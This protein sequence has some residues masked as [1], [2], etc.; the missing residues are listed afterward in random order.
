[1][2]KPDPYTD[3]LNSSVQKQ[4]QFDEKRAAELISAIKRAHVPE[5]E[6]DMLLRTFKNI[7]DKP[8]VLPGRLALATRGA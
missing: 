2:T 8:L 4:L 3:L 6:D 7:V 1:M 5:S